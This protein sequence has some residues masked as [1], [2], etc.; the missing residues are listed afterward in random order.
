MESLQYLARHGI[1]LRG[2]EEGNDN[3]TQLLLLRGKGHPFI[4]EWLT[5]TR[6]QGS[7]YVH[8]NKFNLTSSIQ[9]IKSNKFAIFWY[10]IFI[11]CNVTILLRSIHQYFLGTNLNSSIIC[12]PSSGDTSLF[13]E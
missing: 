12:F 13:Y 6:E 9:Q 7:L 5:S 11:C 3:S 10:S 4:I 2:K 8:H 1:P